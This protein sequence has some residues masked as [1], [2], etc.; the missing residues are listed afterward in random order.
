MEDGLMD[1]DDPKIVALN[2]KLKRCVEEGMVTF[3]LDKDGKLVVIGDFAG[4]AD[5]IG[6]DIFSMCSWNEFIEHS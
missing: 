4:G 2:Q 6:H 1:I 5:T 3:T